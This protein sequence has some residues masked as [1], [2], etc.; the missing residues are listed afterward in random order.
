MSIASTC[1][2]IADSSAVKCLLKSPI[3]DNPIRQ[4]TNPPWRIINNF[5]V[6]NPHAPPPRRRAHRAGLGKSLKELV[7]DIPWLGDQIAPV[8]KAPDI[9][10]SPLSILAPPQLLLRGCGIRTGEQYW[11]PLSRRSRR[12]RR[13]RR[14]AHGCLIRVIGPHSTRRLRTEAN[15]RRINSR[16]ISPPWKSRRMST[17]L[18]IS[19]SAHFIFE[20][21]PSNNTST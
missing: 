14:P 8:V 3:N 6:P 11:I 4:R 2:H 5:P 16:R 10:D 15:R 7:H 9:L 20:S 18:V 19:T 21:A 17:Y 1:D 13:L 12:R